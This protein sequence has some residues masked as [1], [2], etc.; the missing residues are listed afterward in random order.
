[1]SNDIETLMD[2]IQAAVLTGR[3]KE[4]P[5]IGARLESALAQLQKAPTPENLGRLREKAARNQVLLAAAGLGIKA[6]L[7]RIDEIQH[8]Q[9]GSEFYNVAGKRH[10]IASDKETLSR[11]L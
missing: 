4:I 10:H 3:T 2:E 7:R 5:E 6:A 1:M 9:L 11:R 8:A